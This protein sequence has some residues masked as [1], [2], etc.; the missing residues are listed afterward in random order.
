MKKISTAH[1]ILNELTIRVYG[2]VER[3]KSDWVST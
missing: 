2:N 1:N 3:K